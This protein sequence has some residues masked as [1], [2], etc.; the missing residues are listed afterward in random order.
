[1]AGIVY[2]VY[3]SDDRSE[4][5]E[6]RICGA[7]GREDAVNQFR[8]RHN[9]PDIKITLIKEQES[10]TIYQIVTDRIISEMRN[11]VIPWRKPWHGVKDGAISYTTRKPYSLLNQMLL[12]RPGEWLT[13]KQIHELGGRIKKGS[14]AGMVTFWRVYLKGKD[15]EDIPDDTEVMEAVD[16]R[17]V[18]RYYNVYHI[19]DVEGVDSKVEPDDNRPKLQPIDEAESVVAGYVERNSP[20]RVQSTRSNKAY[21]APLSDEVVVPLLEQYDEPEG[22]YSTLFHELT[23]STGHSGRLDRQL[24]MLAKFGSKDY[25]REELVAEIGS[26]MICNRLGFESDKTFKNSVAYLESW[27]TSLENDEK[28][29]VYAASKAEKAA[30]YILNIKDE[31]EAG[32]NR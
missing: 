23:H 4:H 7:K 26:A 8:K 1:M 18:L 32:L 20:L 21:Y 19:D 17:F 6:E 30:K 5:N 3:Y 31:T 14:K 13:W 16:K 12:G 27:L 15:G 2:I 28:L 29:I 11:G 9:S 25:A 22:Y 24:G 10:R